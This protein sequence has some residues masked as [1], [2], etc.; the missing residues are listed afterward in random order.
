MNWSLS[1]VRTLFTLD[2]V[3]AVIYP[4]ETADSKH[5]YDKGHA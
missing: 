2:G 3:V 5:Q 1:Q 4:Q